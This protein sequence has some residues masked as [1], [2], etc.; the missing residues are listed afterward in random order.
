MTAHAL[1][2]KLKLLWK[3]AEQWKIISLGRGF[4]EF[5]FASFE[6]MRLAWSMGTVNLKPGILRLSKWTN[7]FN[8]YTQR[9]THAQIWIRLM[10]LPQEYWRHRTLF[11]IAS[12]VGTPLSLDASTSNRVFGH[13]ARILVDIDLSRHIFDEILVER[14]DF[15]FKL[16]VVY[17]RMPEFCSHCQ[18]TGHDISVCK[19]MKPVQVAERTKKLRQVKKE[20]AQTTMK[21]VE[22]KTVAQPIVE[23]DAGMVADTAMPIDVT[24]ADKVPDAQQAQQ[25]ACIH[26]EE[27]T[28]VQTRVNDHMPET[29]PHL[30]EGTS[31]SFSASLLHVTD[32]IGHGSLQSAHPV[33]QLVAEDGFTENINNEEDILTVPETQFQVVNGDKMPVVLPGTEEV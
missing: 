3:T 16:E 1:S 30:V 6:D 13:Y 8:K 4:Y 22:K 10:D 27:D 5:Q 9:Q 31:T 26:V 29:E 25:L 24:I 17:E 11:E 32:V 7:D 33:L 14:D 23:V 15:D 12:A 21:Y 28:I 19:W 20:A 18:V 2:S